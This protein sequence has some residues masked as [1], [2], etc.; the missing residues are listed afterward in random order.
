MNL[1][2]QPLR[3]SLVDSASDFAPKYAKVMVHNGTEDMKSRA[4]HQEVNIERI[5]LYYRYSRTSRVSRFLARL[6]Y[7]P[8]GCS[9]QHN[10][11][12]HLCVEVIGLLD[13]LSSHKIQCIISETTEPCL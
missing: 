12:S 1:K 2:L 4:L 5:F 9:L 13:P 10:K 11:D 6:F 8:L 3:I 7:F